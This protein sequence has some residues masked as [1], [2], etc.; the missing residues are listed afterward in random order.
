MVCAV[1]NWKKKVGYSEC[2]TR[3]L[4]KHARRAYKPWLVRFWEQDRPGDQAR[5][6]HQLER[7]TLRFSGG[8]GEKFSVWL[9]HLGVEGGGGIGRVSKVATVVLKKES[10]EE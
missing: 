4:G 9:G 3:G 8:W 5:P 2:L 7:L 6:N 1:D 10:E